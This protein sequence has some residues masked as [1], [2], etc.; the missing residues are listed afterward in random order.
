MLTI[1]PQA[2]LRCRTAA[3]RALLSPRRTW[4]LAVLP[5]LAALISPW[6]RN[7]SGPVVWLPA[8][9]VALWA[10]LLRQQTVAAQPI[11]ARRSAIAMVT[12]LSGLYLLWR[13][14]TTLNVSTPTASALS[15]LLLGA[16]GILLAHGLLQLWLAWFRQ[17]PVAE[18]AEQAA[19]QLQR[20]LRGEA[21]RLPAVDVVVPS[22]GEPLHLVARSLQGCLALDYPRTA[23]WLLD[24]AGRPELA[25]LCRQLGCFYLARA[26]HRHA[27]A[28]NLNHSLAHLRGDLLVVFDADVVPQRHFLRRTIGL[29]ADP[30]VAL[31]QTP[32]SYMNPDP[33]IRNLGL[34][35]WLMSDE[36]VF[37]RWIQPT[38]QGVGAVVCAGTSFVLRRSALEQ[39]GGFETGTPSE[40]LATGIRLTAAGYRI[41]YLNEKLSAGLAPPTLVAMARQRSRWASGTL[42]TLRTAASPLFIPGLK[43][44]Q[45][46]AF[47]EGILHWLNAIPQLVLLLMPLSFGLL[48]VSPLLLPDQGAWTIGLPLLLAQVLLVRWFSNGARSALMPELYRWVFLVPLLLAVLSTVLGRPTLFRVTPKT[49]PSG[50]AKPALCLVLPLVVLL[51]LQLI[52]LVLLV[53]ATSSILPLFWSALACISLLAALRACW[54]RFPSDAAVWFRPLDTTVTV[55]QGPRR[56]PARLTAI[57]ERGVELYWP[58]PALGEPGLAMDLP[59]Q[60]QAPWFGSLPLAAQPQR[61][62]HARGRVSLGASWLW[63]SQDESLQLQ[64]RLYQQPGAWPVRQ[65]PSDLLAIPALLLRLLRPPGPEGWLARSALPIGLDRGP[66]AAIPPV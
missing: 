16:E 35:H 55:A 37:Y 60:I 52:N 25:E 7:A 30:R 33:V 19:H 5:L 11:T 49:V 54:D 21:D 47:L 56:W 15:L 39:I 8:L 61:R 38:R 29:F 31:V 32:Q 1:H 59:L 50:A 63:R 2:L 27:K 3:G 51:G 26:D 64:A 62:R 20:A 22:R 6:L 53:R 12:L 9:L 65:A 46:V 58:A 45:R 41:L 34:E 24:D 10:L 14:T 44:L 18:E 28:G 13:A 57:S 17:P 23:V 40:D 66:G 4:W 43:P 48:G 42:Q 36:E